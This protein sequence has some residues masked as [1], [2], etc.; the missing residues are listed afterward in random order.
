MRP[1]N[2]EGSISILGTKG[3]AKIEAFVLNKIEYYNLQKDIKFS[4]Y[5]TKKMFIT[6]GMLSITNMLSDQ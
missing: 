1:K 5:Q 6:L 3:S 4:K 2:I